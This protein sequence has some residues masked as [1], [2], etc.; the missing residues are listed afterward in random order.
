MSSSRDLIGRCFGQW[1]VVGRGPNTPA[2]KTTWFCRCQCGEQR[3]VV[4][5]NLL[6]GGSRSCGCA[7]AELSAARARSRSTRHGHSARGSVSSEYASWASMR[8][9]CKYKCVRGFEHYGGRGIIVCPRWE[10]F[11]NFLADMGPKPTPRHTID[12]IDSNGNYEPGNCRW[13]TRR[14]QAKNKRAHAQKCPA[15]Q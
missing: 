7:A 3:R 14:E 13:A 9:R 5:G 15:L 4:G 8:A 1:T 10:T 6:S 2:R 11:S 12:R